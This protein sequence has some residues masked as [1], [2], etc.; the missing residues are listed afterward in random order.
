MNIIFTNNTKNNIM[1]LPT[2]IQK[3][4]YIYAFKLLWRNYIPLTAKV[5]SWMERKNYIDKLLWEARLKNI[6][7][8]HLPFNTLPENKKWIMGCQCNFCLNDNSISEI[9]K[10][11]HYLVQYRNSYYFEEKFMENCKSYSSNWNQHI[12]WPLLNKFFDPLCGSY[13]EN[14]FT[15]KIR[16]NTPFTFSDYD[17]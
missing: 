15:K 12:L 4:I 11:C 14:S 5:P 9:E 2:E 1:K 7:F 13:K 6:H 3:K 17:F 8:M 16:N 10:H